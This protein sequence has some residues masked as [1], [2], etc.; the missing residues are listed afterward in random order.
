MQCCL[1]VNLGDDSVRIF[2]APAGQYFELGPA[3]AKEQGLWRHDGEPDA[4]YSDTLELDMSTVE[5]SIAGPKRP[6]DRI[7]LS[8]A[9]K[10]YGGHLKKAIADRKVIYGSPLGWLVFDSELERAA[11]VEITVLGERLYLELRFF[12]D[13]GAMPREGDAAFKGF[14]RVV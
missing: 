5:P 2:Q 3:Y 10:T 11:L 8:A 9:A 13:H 6:Q 14:E 4:L 12:K 7:A 1:P